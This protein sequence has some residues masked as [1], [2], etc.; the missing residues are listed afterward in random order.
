MQTTILGFPAVQFI[1]DQ[2]DVL[3]ISTHGYHKEGILLTGNGRFG[4]SDTDWHK[5][6]DIVVIAGCSVLDVTGHKW[7][8]PKN[9]EAPGR[10]WVETG[11][12]LLLGYEAAAPT[13]LFF[14]W[15]ALPEDAGPKQVVESWVQRMEIYWESPAY[16]WLWVNWFY[17]VVVNKLCHNACAIDAWSSPRSAY[18]LIGNVGGLFNSNLHQVDESG[19]AGEE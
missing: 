12:G 18:H 13:D 8:A 10:K 17:Q 3:Y 2:A 1:P 7:P 11:P 16:A 5:G 4:P 14:H 6:L 9:T 15:Y 19:W